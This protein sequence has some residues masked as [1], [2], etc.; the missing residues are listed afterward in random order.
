MPMHLRRL[1]LLFVATAG[2]AVAAATGVATTAATAAG[3][4][5]IFSGQATALSAKILDL[6]TITVADTGYFEAE[7]FASPDT[8]TDV[9]VPPLTDQLR[10]EAE[11]FCSTTRADG[12][13]SA[14]DSYIAAL[15]A[16]VAG[17]PVSATLLQSSASASCGATGPL[18]ENEEVNLADVR[19]GNVVVDLDAAV[20]TPRNE[21]IMIDPVL[22]SY[23]VV[24]QRTVTSN[25][26]YSSLTLTALRVVV[27]GV[28]DVS[29]ATVH[30][31]VRC[32]GRPACPAPS[33][34]TGGGFI[35]GKR[36]F[37]IGVRD[38]DLDWGHFMYS[39]KASGLKV[40]GVKSFLLASVYDAAGTEGEAQ[41]AGNAKVVKNG[42]AQTQLVPFHVRVTDRGE[43]G[44]SD[45]F[46]LKLG[47]ELIAAGSL[48][49][50]NVQAHRPCKTR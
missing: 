37:T 16:T 22:G 45:W 5:P 49:G 40:T 18:F 3:D 7:T 12:N 24:G 25:G 26:N 44:R 6:P 42:V 29:F 13:E 27:P 15:D 2:L 47:G 35:S 30:V 50:G 48:E 8:C 32:Q 28:A 33:F 11:I 34:V 36:Y 23:F 14:S 21:P 46:E 17:I 41:L 43:P 20:P 38:G 1:S 31:D 10:A 4:R 9:G 19:V 39:N